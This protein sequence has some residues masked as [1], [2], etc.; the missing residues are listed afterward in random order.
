MSFAEYDPFCALQACFEGVKMVAIKTMSEFI[1]FVSS[2][3]NVNISISLLVSRSRQSCPRSTSFVSSTSI[4]TFDHMKKLKNNT[5]VGNTGHSVNEIDLA[6]PEGLDIKP[7]SCLRFPRWS[8][9]DRAGFRKSTTIDLAS[10]E[11][12]DGMKVDPPLVQSS[13]SLLRNKQI[14]Q[15]SR[16]SK[17]QSKVNSE[18][19]L[20]GMKVDNTSLPLVTVWSCKNVSTSCRDSSTRKWE[21]SLSGT[22]HGAHRPYPRT[23]NFFIVVEAEGPFKDPH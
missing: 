9:R 21:N 6:G 8:Q 22:Q 2:T 1:I 17:V 19:G 5:F 13:P 20:E 11:G 4:I 3:G 14:M 23:N 7:Q 15:V 10:S 18:E 16:L 12:L